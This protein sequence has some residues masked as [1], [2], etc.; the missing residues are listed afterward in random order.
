MTREELMATTHHPHPYSVDELR[1]DIEAGHVDTVIVAFTDMQGRL[2]GKRLHAG[3][4]LDDVLPTGRRA[5]T[6]SSPSMSR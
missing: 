5:A 4:F 2:Q 1:R 6:T 3:I